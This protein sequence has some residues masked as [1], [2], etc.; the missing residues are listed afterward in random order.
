[1]GRNFVYTKKN[2]W[3]LSCAQ[4]KIY[5]E[6]K[7]ILVQKMSWQKLKDVFTTNTTKLK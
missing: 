3:W 6:A 2:T 4:P 5:D 7:G 1:M